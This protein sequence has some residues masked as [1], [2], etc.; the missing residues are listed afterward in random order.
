MTT[1][2][3]NATTPPPSRK[4]GAGTRWVVGCLV[5]LLVVGALAGAAFW[6]FV[7]R[8]LGQIARAAADV[9]RV[10]AL[11]E[12]VRDRSTFVPPAD[13]RLEAAQVE[14]YVNVLGDVRS[15]LEGRL[16]RLEARFEAIDGQRPTWRDVSSLAGA[17][18]DL[19]RLAVEAKEAQVEALNAQGFSLSEL[20]WVR[21]EVV[22]A[23]GL[24]AAD[25]D[26]TAYVQGLT[27]GRA[28]EARQLDPS[29]APPEN[30]ALV[31]GVR[32]R[33]DEVAVLL[34]LGF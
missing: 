16:A 10:A 21:Q 34:L 18:A 19:L 29:T 12:R 24:P 4:P 25:V 8:P 3:P 28:P 27:A 30:R 9:T 1:V 22:R 2:S 20:R 6:W 31:A 5:A 7:G 13:G 23:A 15:S 17:Y 11:D 33:L 26:L 32:E 14:R